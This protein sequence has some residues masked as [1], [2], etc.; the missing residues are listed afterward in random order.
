MIEEAI[1]CVSD[2]RHNK[3]GA[4]PLECDIRKLMQTSE[5]EC[6]PKTDPVTTRLTKRTS[7]Y[8]FGMFDLKLTN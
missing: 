8:P 7:A 3:T 5:P 2:M 6:C 4:V 1:A